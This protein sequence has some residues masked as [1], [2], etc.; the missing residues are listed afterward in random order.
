MICKKWLKVSNIG[1]VQS[2]MYGICRVPFLFRKPL[3]KITFFKSFA[4][5]TLRLWISK[6]QIWIW[7]EESTQLECG[8]YGFM[9]RFWIC[10]K[11]RKIRF[12][13]PNSRFGFSKKTHPKWAR[14]QLCTCS[15][16]FLYISLP[17]FCTTTTW[18]V[19]N[20]LILVTCIFIFTLHLIGG[21]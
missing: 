8:F 12:W 3:V 17:L 7:S 5:K 20:L 10:P 16:L 18:N 1:S 13:I 15:I 19:H 11:K 21:R 6:I 4:K 14:K 9:I 2:Y